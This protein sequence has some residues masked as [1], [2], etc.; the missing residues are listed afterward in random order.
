MWFGSYFRR[1]G[2]T[3]GVKRLFESGE[4]ADVGVIVALAF[5]PRAVVAEEGFD[6]LG[7]VVG[8]LTVDMDDERGVFVVAVVDDEREFVELLGVTVVAELLGN[9]VGEIGE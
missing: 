4:N 2:P 6:A 8:L 1:S 5:G 9:E 7:E 3:S